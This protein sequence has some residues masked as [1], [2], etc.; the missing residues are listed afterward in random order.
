MFSVLN[1]RFKANQARA[2]GLFVISGISL[3]G[4]LMCTI[5][6]ISLVIEGLQPKPYQMLCGIAGGLLILIAFLSCWAANTFRD[7]NIKPGITTFNNKI[8]SAFIPS[9]NMEGRP[10]LDIEKPFNDTEE[11]DGLTIFEALKNTPPVKF[12]VEILE[13]FRKHGPAIK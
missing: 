11:I 2:G 6:Y 8:G 5:G 4:C 7:T 13:R 12:V 3:I 9:G 10:S 1:K